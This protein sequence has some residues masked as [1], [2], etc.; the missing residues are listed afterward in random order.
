M[1]YKLSFQLFSDTL[2]DIWK[3]KGDGVPTKQRRIQQ[4]N[5]TWFPKWFS[6]VE[7]FYYFFFFFRCVSSFFIPSYQSVSRSNGIIA[8]SEDVW[9]WLMLSICSVK[10]DYMWKL[11]SSRDINQTQPHCELTSLSPKCYLIF[12][13]LCMAYTSGSKT[14]ASSDLT[15][16]A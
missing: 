4:C 13:G 9:Q 15:C 12:H 10:F 16:R 1:S 6:S 5:L 14:F 8:S 3:F 7:Y 11:F 2:M